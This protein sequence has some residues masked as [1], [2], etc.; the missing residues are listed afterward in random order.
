MKKLQHFF[1]I[2]NRSKKKNINRKQCE[3]NP[4][5]ESNNVDPS[6][7]LELSKKSNSK[8]KSTE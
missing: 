5:D 4:V 8:C 2:T 6:E 1:T 3:I 7:P